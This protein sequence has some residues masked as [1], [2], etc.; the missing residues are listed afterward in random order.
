MFKTLSQRKSNPSSN[1]R[2]TVAEFFHLSD[3]GQSGSGATFARRSFN[4]VIDVG[5]LDKKL[6]KLFLDWR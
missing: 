6:V 3:G 4:K 1:W 5:R 2:L